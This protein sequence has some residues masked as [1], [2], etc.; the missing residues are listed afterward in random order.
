LL[1]RPHASRLV[2]PLVGLCL[3]QLGWHVATLLNRVFGEY[4]WR[5]LDLAISPL[6]AP[7]LL[8]VVLVFVGRRKQWRGFLLVTYV[9]FGLI[10]SVS[11]LSLVSA[12][13]D[14]VT[15]SHGW[16]TFYA[17]TAALLIPVGVALLWRH[18]ERTAGSDEQARA[19]LLLAGSLALTVL[20]LAE[21]ILG[22]RGLPLPLAAVG[23]ALFNAVVAV[24]ALRF[25]LFEREL[26]TSSA[27]FAGLIALVALVATACIF[28]VVPVT[29]RPWVAACTALVF[30]VSGL[31]TFR[32]RSIF[33]RRL[34]LQE[35]LTLGQFA[36]QM[37]HDLRNPL[38]A[39]KG[40]A[41]FLQNDSS[42]SQLSKEARELLGLIVTQA[43]RLESQIQRYQRLERLEPHCTAADVQEILQHLVSVQSSSTPGVQW[44]LDV[45]PALPP[46]RMDVDLVGAS[47]DNLLRNAL[48]AMPRGGRLQVTA[49]RDELDGAPGLRIQV[50]D[51]GAGM[52]P[53]TQESA[54]EDFFTTK[55]TGQG[56]GLA[57]VRRVADAHGGRTWIESSVGQGT[58][59]SLWLPERSA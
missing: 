43:D 22:L 56:I 39:L 57:F 25:Q 5:A 35:L 28:I 37:A 18:S 1:W 59:A 52:D 27:F 7:L 34:R 9:V 17:T 14:S 3:V 2:L 31:S 54:F 32:L 38:A 45:Q 55:P 44:V 26:S 53:R 33:S 13:L 15:R 23:G 58:R 20:A 50:S 16:I 8:H 24:I 11:L 6:T 4:P 19:H 12:S 51:T 46:W 36:R 30:A 21:L 29:V 40:A 48:D 10:S 49:K 41:Q 47:L 42:A